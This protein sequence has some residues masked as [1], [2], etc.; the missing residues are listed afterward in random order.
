METGDDRVP[1]GQ[2]AARATAEKGRGV[3]LANDR[4]YLAWDPLRWPFRAGAG[5]G[6]DRSR[7]RPIG[8]PWPFVATGCAHAV[9]AAV[10]GLY[11][12]HRHRVVERAV[13]IGGFVET[14]A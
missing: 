4:T 10:F 3:P 7:A 11:G 9:L 12:L 5:D 1:A 13:V 14:S 2:D 6:K 8:I